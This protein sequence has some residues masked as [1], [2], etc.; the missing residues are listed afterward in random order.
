LIEDAADV[1]RALAL[2]Y[3]ILQLCTG[4]LGFA[5]ADKVDLETWASGSGEWLEVS[6]CGNFLDFQA[7]RT[8][9]R[10]RPEAGGRPR[11][12]HTLNGS[13]LA[14]PRTM[15]AIMEHYQQEDGTIEVPAVLRPYLGG[16][17]T[18]G[19]QPPIGPARRSP[20]G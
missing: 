4:D 18:I 1:L 15:I 5:A 20:G 3:R 12:V 11:F 14:L 17:E 13:G 7:R 19:V 16:Q 10:F 6:S 8:N 9:I 2:P